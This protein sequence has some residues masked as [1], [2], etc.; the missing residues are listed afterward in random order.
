MITQWP[1]VFFTV[2]TQLSAGLALFSALRTRWGAGP[3]P[4]GWKTAAIAATVAF[5]SGFFSC[6]GIESGAMLAAQIS[7]LL[8]AVFSCGAL[9]KII[10]CSGAACMAGSLCVLAQALA[11]VPGELLSPSGFFPFLLFPLCTLVLGAAFTQLP[12]LDE[13]N[14]NAIRYGRF[15]LPLRFS[16]WLMLVITAAAPCL[17][18]EDPFMKKA[19]FY[20]MQTQLYW[21]GVIFSGVVIGLS[22]MGR[23]TLYLQAAIAF[24][25]VLGLRTAFYADSVHGAIDLGTLYMR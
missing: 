11:A 22:H 3:S 7:C 2:F 15:Y 4:R 24:V 6:G 1:L 18:W 17:I 25:S 20:W 19:S 8:L 12:C 23:I 13:P 16:L 21:M 10:L 14:D 9:C 5:A